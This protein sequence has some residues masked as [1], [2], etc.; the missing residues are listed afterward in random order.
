MRQ[1]K[2]K[3][4]H[5]AGKYTINITDDDKVKYYTHKLLMMWVRK[6]HNGTYE[7][8]QKFVRKNIVGK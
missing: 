7:K 1:F 4:T 8:M 2:P 5:S 3:L 6:Y